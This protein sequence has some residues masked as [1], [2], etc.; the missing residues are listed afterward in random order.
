MFGLGA[1]ELLLILA[2]ILF[3]YGGKRLP[4]IGEGLGR[5]VSE[6]KKAI[7][8][9]ETPMENKRTMLSDQT[10]RDGKRSS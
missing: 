5:F 6:F 4:A 7:R 8:P 10:E 2:V 9:D 3:F 1:M